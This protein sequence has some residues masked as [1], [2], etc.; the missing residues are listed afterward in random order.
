VT[1]VVLSAAATIAACLALAAQEQ[2][3]TFRSGTRLVE[4]T[5]TALDKKGQAVTDL[6]LQD[7]TIQ[8]LRSQI[9]VIFAERGPNGSTRLTTDTHT[10]KIAAQ[11][12]EA[13]QQE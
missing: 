11:N 12:W 6:R 8:G 3:P 10:V 4:L 2:P 13:A 1:P 7:F 9:Q 5:V